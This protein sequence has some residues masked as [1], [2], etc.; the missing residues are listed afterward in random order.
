MRTRIRVLLAGVAVAAAAGG[1]QGQAATAGRFTITPV[2]GTIRWDNTSALA[3]KTADDNGAFT[4][5][6]IT[7]T[8]GLSAEYQLAREIGVGFYFEAARPTTRGDYFPAV[9]FNFGS[10]LPTQLRSVSQRVTVLMYGVQGSLGF[11]AGNLRPYVSGGVGAVTVNA[12]PQQSDRNASFTHGQFQLGGGIGW[13]TG[14]S[15]SVRLD[16]RDYVFTSWDRNELNPV[17]P[18]FQN[19]LFPS[20]NATPPAAKSTVHNIRLALGFSYVPRRV[21][22]TAT[23]PEGQE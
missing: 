22:G 2:I 19:T 4:K 17:S 1:A 8:V 6:A 12:D 11:A 14:R 21:E 23:S 9:L 20:A 3:N 13:Q 5:T 18:A 7:P 16:L 10:N 15:G